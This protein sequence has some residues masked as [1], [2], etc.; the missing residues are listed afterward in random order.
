MQNNLNLKKNYRKDSFSD[1]DKIVFTTISIFL[2][3]NNGVLSPIIPP[4]IPIGITGEIILLPLL[5]YF[6]YK[7]KIEINFI[8]V[9][10]ILFN[11]LTL[12][13]ALISFKDYGL[14]SL[15]TTTYCIDSGYILIGAVIAKNQF[16]R[17]K[18]PKLFWR[19]FYLGSIYNLTIPFKYF[20]IQF[21]PILT[22]FAGYQVPLFFNY[23][24][25]AIISITF[26]F[27]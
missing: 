18:L 21:T 20:L 13:S 22:A 7:Q 16:K 14:Q 2:I 23:S 26:F 24:T 5:I 6:F 15:R 12:F 27:F 10:I 1:I 25:A 11:L 17:A 4:G 8:T 9:L 19:I 3:L